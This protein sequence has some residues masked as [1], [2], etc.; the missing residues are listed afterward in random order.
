MKRRSFLVSTLASTG[1]LL[2]PSV[3]V[4]AK[5]QP[6]ESP[7]GL[8]EGVPYVSAEATYFARYQHFHLLSIPLDVL[9]EAPKDGYATRCSPLDQ[10]SLDEVA[11]AK[12]LDE[13]GLKDEALRHHSHLVKFTQQDLLRIGSGEENVEITVMTPG[14]NLG[15][16]FYFTA[17]KSAVL[18]IQR[19]HKPD[20]SLLT[21]HTEDSPFFEHYHALQIPVE[22][23]VNPPLAGI[24]LTTTNVDQGSIDEAGFD[25][26]IQQ[27]GL[28]RE[29]FRNHSHAVTLTRDD[30]VRIGRGDT[31]E[32]RI[33][34]GNGNYVHNF[35]ITALK[36][37]I[38]KAQNG[39][40]K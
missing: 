2:L 16:R 34:S 13:T 27:S 29:K 5:E 37:V 32:I 17:P 22:A 4:L 9:I 36:N 14:G 33:V 19:K 25:K 28:P 10:A 31:V 21:V 3:S 7:L 6:G 1:A 35:K 39:L 30:L 40:K 23:I 11:F 38:V 15:H 12:F 24:T 18:N 20:L 8:S 26:F